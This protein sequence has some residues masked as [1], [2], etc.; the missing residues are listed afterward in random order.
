MRLELKN[1]AFLSSAPNRRNAV[2]FEPIFSPCHCVL[3]Q[4][5]K[6]FTCNVG[7][8]L[9]QLPSGPRQRTALFD[10]S[11][12][13]LSGLG[14]IAEA[15]GILGLRSDAAAGAVCDILDEKLL[16]DDSSW[17][18]QRA[19]TL[20]LSQVHFFIHNSLF[21]LHADIAG[22]L[23]TQTSGAD[24]KSEEASALVSRARRSRPRSAA[25]KGDTLFEVTPLTK[26]CALV[27][28]LLRALTLVLKAQQHL[29]ASSHQALTKTDALRGLKGAARSLG[30]VRRFETDLLPQLGYS[31]R[32]RAQ[33]AMRST[34][35]ANLTIA[36]SIAEHALE[37]RAAALRVRSG[38]VDTLQ[39]RFSASDR[40]GVALVVVDVR[41]R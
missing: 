5:A 37:A 31:L 11:S 12:C 26:T 20:A 10:T 16:D 35:K 39:T 24:S 27:E 13:S 9:Q 14:D 32:P 33:P 25:S 8:A 1:P 18:N 21:D 30:L 3:A 28:H 6:C 41:I 22:Q 23:E 17:E 15:L 2:S 29:Q 19:S 34:R 4:L 40:V 38:L 36:S 7:R